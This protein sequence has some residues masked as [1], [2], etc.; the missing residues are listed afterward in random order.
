MLQ[1]ELGTYLQELTLTKVE[2]IKII[3]DKI[4]P[5]ENP[6]QDFKSQIPDFQVHLNSVKVQLRDKL[7]KLQTLHEKCMA[8]SK[9][10]HIIVTLN[11]VEQLLKL[12]PGD[13][14][15]NLDL[16]E[17]IASDVNYLTKYHSAPFVQD[18][19]PMIN[20]IGDR[21]HSALAMQLM[22][23]LQDNN[24]DVLKRYLRI[25][26]TI[27]KVDQAEQLIRTKIIAP[28]LEEVLLSLASYHLDPLGLQELCQKVLK[29]IPEKLALLLKL[30]KK[31]SFDSVCLVDKLE[32][33]LSFIFSV[34]NPDQ[35]HKNYTVMIKFLKDL[36]EHMKTSTNL[37]Q[38]IGDR[39]I[40]PH[41]IQLMDALQDNNA[42][43]LKKC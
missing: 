6:L 32:Q 1:Y 17:C 36:Q 34:G 40:S 21:L 25:Y 8:L 14:Q 13:D 43:V 28:Y 15:D 23:V 29:I 39:L 12:N 38:F 27:D 18:I 11:K 16:I 19:M 9:L 2:V 7:A 41:S 3:E 24:A 30:Q 42:D 4:Q 37:E 35:F 10:E 33:N 5:M 26:T 31:Q 22:E 20:F